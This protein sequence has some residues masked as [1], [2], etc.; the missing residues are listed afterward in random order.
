MNKTLSA[1]LLLIMLSGCRTAAPVIIEK[2]IV[3]PG[4]KDTAIILRDTVI[5]KDS[6]WLGEVK[7]SI[8]REIGNLKIYF[9]KKL[10]ELKINERRDTIYVK[11]PVPADDKSGSLL[12]LVDIGLEWWEKIILYGGIGIIISILIYFRAT[13]GKI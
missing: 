9:S 6:L 12:H 1:V 13:K 10:A 4:I 11:V 8:G 2:S 3:I 7:D 5:Q